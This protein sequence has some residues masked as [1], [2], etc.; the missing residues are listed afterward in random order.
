MHIRTGKREDDEYAKH[1]KPRVL[2]GFYPPPF[3]F[4]VAPKPAKPETVATAVGTEDE[5]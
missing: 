3:L 4:A 5:D 1:R 2:K